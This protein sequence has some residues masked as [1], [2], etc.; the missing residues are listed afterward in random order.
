[1]N[2]FR[3]RGVSRDRL[4][5]FFKYEASYPSYP[6]SCI[7]HFKGDHSVKSKFYHL[8]FHLNAPKCH[9]R[10][11]NEQSPIPLRINVGLNRQIRGMSIRLF[12]APYVEIREH[13]YG[14]RFHHRD[15]RS[16]CM[17]NSSMRE[18]SGKKSIMQDWSG[19]P[20]ES[21]DGSFNLP[22]RDS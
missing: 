4:L 8:V 10:S 7:C 12:T 19:I 17:K 11:G 16:R 18:R 13:N 5:V 20:F 1:M 9:A 3:K 14:S 21:L 15:P 6:V 22:A 2:A